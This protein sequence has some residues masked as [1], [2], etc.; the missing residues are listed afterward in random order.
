MLCGRTFSSL[1]ILSL[2]ALGSGA[3]ARHETR[4]LATTSFSA[5]SRQAGLDGSLRAGLGYGRKG[6]FCLAEYGETRA[7]RRV[8]NVIVFSA[9]NPSCFL[10]SRGFPAVLWYLYCGAARR[11][12]RQGGG[13][14]NLGVDEA[15]ADDACCE[16]R[17]PS[18][19]GRLCRFRAWCAAWRRVIVGHVLPRKPLPEV[20]SAASVALLCSGASRAA[21]D[22][23]M[24]NALG[25]SQR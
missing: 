6:N 4:A 7:D 13:R 14:G 25:C 9:E 20:Q 8:R 5:S 19:V 18:L 2:A 11:G 21:F 23:L 17:G 22:L 24:A 10:R 16:L 12:R 1:S 15:R 3:A